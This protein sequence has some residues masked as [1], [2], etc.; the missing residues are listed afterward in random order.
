MKTSTSVL[1]E[2]VLGPL[3]NITVMMFSQQGQQ[4]QMVP[5]STWSNC[6]CLFG[7]KENCQKGEN[8]ASGS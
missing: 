3:V 4:G 6:V 2:T 8:G 7:Y 1:F 5:R